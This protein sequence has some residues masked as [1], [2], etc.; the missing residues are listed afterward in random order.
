VDDAR[1]LDGAGCRVEAVQRPFV[2]DGVGR[3]HHAVRARLGA[4][5]DRSFA[6]G[7]QYVD[8]IV[9]DDRAGVREAGDGHVPPDAVPLRRIP[10]DGRRR[11]RDA[12]RVRA[13]KGRP[14]FGAGVEGEREG[15]GGRQAGNL[16]H[17]HTRRASLSALK[18]DDVKRP[19]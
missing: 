10:V 2:H 7:A 8:A 15:G 17:A 3:E 12:A 14:V 6:D 13:A 9:P 1:P 18:A 4:I 11:V 5:E 16:L 19:A